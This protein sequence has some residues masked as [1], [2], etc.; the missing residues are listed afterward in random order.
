MACCGLPVKTNNEDSSEDILEDNDC[1]AAGTVTAEGVDL[2]V[3]A[4][5]GYEEQ[6]QDLEVL[7][8]AKRGKEE[9]RTVLKITYVSTK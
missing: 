2:A 4:I 3:P 6:V 8:H 1:D 5:E 9:G 7:L